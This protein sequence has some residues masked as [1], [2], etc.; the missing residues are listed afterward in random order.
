MR[1]IGRVPCL[2]GFD[3]FSLVKF[4]GRLAALTSSA[5]MA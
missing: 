5:L 4:S 3:M 1:D 2:L